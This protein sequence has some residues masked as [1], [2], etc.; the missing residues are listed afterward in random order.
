MARLRYSTS[1]FSVIRTLTDH[2]ERF[3]VL[4]RTESGEPM[5]LALRYSL[6]HRYVDGSGELERRLKS[7]AWLYEWYDRHGH[8]TGSDLEARI[9]SPDFVSDAELRLAMVYADTGGHVASLPTPTQ[10][11]AT[12]TIMRPALHNTRMRHWSH[13]LEW[14]L[15]PKS[16]RTG[17][18]RRESGTE[19]AARES[20]AEEMGLF[21]DAAQRVTPKY[22][23]RRGFKE[24]EDAVL[25]DLLV[26]EGELVWRP[27]HDSVGEPLFLFGETTRLRNYLLFALMRGLGL[28]RGEVL[29]L[30]IEDLPRPVG[31]DPG[32]QEVRWSQDQSLWVRRREDDKADEGRRIEPK[33]KRADRPVPIQADL[34]SDLW[35]YIE[36]PAPWGRAA[37]TNPYLFVTDRGRPLSLSATDDIKQQ[38]RFEASAEC[39]RRW[40]GRMHSL[41]QFT[42]HRL[43]HTRAREVY[44]EMKD[45]FEG[46]QE[47]FRMLFGWSS[48]TS[49]APYIGDQHHEDA[50]AT[51]EYYDSLRHQSFR[52][53]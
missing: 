16:W 45:A 6:E 51:L 53:R 37:V 13:F 34:L 39:A 26:P 52:T 30:R 14:A 3:P 1:R 27:L 40:P 24:F 48:M 19:R 4:V 7:L 2:G 9:R 33:V 17:S 23:N 10:T 21:F 8:M 20:V 29:K 32:T 11:I 44:R 28:R 35:T 41:D 15:L 43:R 12:T 50:R 18:V 42:W 49:A 36:S 5:T 25:H 22:G 47:T 46:W 38:I 31:R